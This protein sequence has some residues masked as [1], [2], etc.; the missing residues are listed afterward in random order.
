MKQIKPTMESVK[1]KMTRR[2]LFVLLCVICV[3]IQEGI[4]K[5]KVAGTVIWS[6][7]I[8][9]KS[10]AIS[11]LFSDALQYRMIP[12]VRACIHDIRVHD[13]MCMTFGD[14]LKKLANVTHNL[15]KTATESGNTGQ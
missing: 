9:C 4:A 5:Y 10:H 8:S 1:T 15:P 3:V 6:Y 13:K 11:S 7:N 2:K 14:Q 12:T